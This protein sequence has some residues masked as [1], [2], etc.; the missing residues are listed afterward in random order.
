MYGRY[1]RLTIMILM[2][3]FDW[4]T[5]FNYTVHKEMNRFLDFE[6]MPALYWK[7]GWPDYRGLAWT[8]RLILRTRCRE[9][10]FIKSLSRTDR[11]SIV[12]PDRDCLLYN[13]APSPVPDHI[14]N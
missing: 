7:P 13:R 3:T 9:T 2:V 1:Y 4:T 12:L 8:V 10:C 14:Q 11:L 6:K 5:S